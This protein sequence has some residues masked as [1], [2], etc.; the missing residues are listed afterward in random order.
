MVLFLLFFLLLISSFLFTSLLLLSFLFP[1]LTAENMS[2]NVYF[3]SLSSQTIV[4][5]GQLT[6]EQVFPY[7]KDLQSP[8]FS[9]HMAL[10]HSR[11]STNTFPSWDRAQPNRMICHNGEIN[12]LR[13]NKNWM[14][15][16]DGLIASSLF[17]E[18]YRQGNISY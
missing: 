18:D 15:S 12:T 11:F 2:G 16:R 3:C 13:G 4:Y 6:P 14:F 1:F 10:V 17:G 9:S 7:F 8:D 5:K